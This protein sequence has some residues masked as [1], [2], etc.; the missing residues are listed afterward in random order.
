MVDFKVDVDV[1]QQL[2]SQLA[3]IH[4]ALSTAKTDF[5]DAAD[6]FSC[7]AVAGALHSF[8]DGWRDGRSKI[9]QETAALS[10]AVAGVAE[11]YA[12]GERD[13]QGSFERHGGR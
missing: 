1:L 10:S 2:S 13:I 9:E 6:A 4:D 8:C 7:D 3:Q 12:E 11:D 5:G